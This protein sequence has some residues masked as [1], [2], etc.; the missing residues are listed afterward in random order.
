[1]SNHNV[2]KCSYVFLFLDSSPFNSY[3][4]LIIY[5]FKALEPTKTKDTWTFMNVVIWRKSVSS[6][7]TSYHI[8]HW[9]QQ[10]LSLS[11]SSEP[12]A[13]HATLL[14]LPAGTLNSQDLLLFMVHAFRMRIMTEN[15]HPI[16]I[17]W[18]KKKIIWLL[19]DY[20]RYCSVLYKTIGVAKW[21]C[22]YQFF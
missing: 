17:V 7:P 16:R 15:D 1:M 20:Q 22:V 9:L 5:W 8:I 10:Y 3:T 2:H 13:P 19:E 4:L 11:L 18:T 21:E 12:S 6:V 14:L